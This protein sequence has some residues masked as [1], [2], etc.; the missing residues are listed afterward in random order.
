[1]RR[2]SVI[3]FI[4]YLFATGFTYAAELDNYY[5]EQFGESVPTSTK[6]AL[7]STSSPQLHKCGMPI[8]KSLRNDWKKLES[9]TQKTLAKYLSKPVLLGE[10]TVSS[11]GGHFIIHYAT[12]ANT[13][14]T[15]IIDDR[16][17]PV[18]PYTVASWVQQVANTFEDVYTKEVTSMGYTPPAPTYH[19]YLQQLASQRVFGITEPETNSNLNVILTGQSAQSS[20]TIDNDFAELVFQNQIP[21]NDTPA[22]KSLKA[23]EITAAHEFHH[24]IQFF[25]NYFFETWYAEATSTWME[26]ETYDSVNQLYN[27]SSDYLLTPSESLNTPADGGYSRWIFNRLITEN[28]NSAAI[29]SIWDKLRNTLSTNNSDI[30]MIPVINSALTSLQSDFPTEFTSFAKRFYTQ[31]W[32]SHTN[33]LSLLYHV[34][35]TIKATYSAYPVNSSST[36]QPTA[37]LPAYS[38]AYYKFI[39]SSSAPINLNITFSA[40]G[41]LKVTAF[42]KTTGNIITEY[43]LTT[44][45]G[46]LTVDSFG[47]AG[48]AEAAL[49]ICNPTAAPATV[50]FSTDG[51][52]P[53]NPSNS[54]GGG[55]GCFIATAAYGSYLHPKVMILRDFR[56]GYLLTNMPGRL[57]VAAYYK[58]SPPIAEFISR[59]E[60][61]RFIIRLLLAPVI[62]TVEH[63]WLML[64][65]SS[66]LVGGFALRLH[67][68]RK[69]QMCNGIS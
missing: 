16:P 7:K 42:K 17:N 20:I 60:Q 38:L 48:V 8:R 44:N 27:Y 19:V 62:F 49:V 24:A 37:T 25:Y 22:V 56:D 40:T 34:P 13:T 50:S 45:G 5:L 11:S 57:L 21:G 3:A 47:V 46:A 63:F 36:V 55:G 10:S 66:L 61:L 23:L 54:G 43:P 58:I 30:P 69:F 9:G 6:T 64:A 52:T 39:P 32:T 59:H 68:R 15:P 35:L 18:A 53:P 67:R 29:R 65:A 14:V 1:M 31:S 51:T 12:L 26:D 28:H 4:L 33:E 2:F 41:G